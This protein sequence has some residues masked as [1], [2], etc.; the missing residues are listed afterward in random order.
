MKFDRVFKKSEI[1]TPKPINNST[2]SNG[3]IKTN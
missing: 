3:G 2:L 1:L